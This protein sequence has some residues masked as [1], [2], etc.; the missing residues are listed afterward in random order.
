MAPCPTWVGLLLGGREGAGGREEAPAL[1]ARWRGRLA[2]LHGS[3]LLTAADL[4]AL[5]EA[6]T[7]ASA[8][9]AA[10]AVQAMP[11]ELGGAPR[12]EQFGRDAWT[13]QAF[14]GRAL[15]MA[16]EHAAAVPLLRAVTGAC[17]P[18]DEPFVYVWASA[19]LGEALEASG[20]KAG[21]CAAYGSVV[22]R[23]GAAER[24]RSAAQARARRRQLGCR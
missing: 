20:D 23:W 9:E 10:R 24:S 2:K 17:I 11:A 16:G 13:A 3:G 12:P 8:S 22:G 21:A 6:A 14:A 19:W 1:D 15:S 5:T 4:W 7:V 18:L